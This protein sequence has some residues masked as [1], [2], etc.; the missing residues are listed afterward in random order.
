VVVREEVWIEAGGRVL[1]ADPEH[2][3]PLRRLSLDGNAVEGGQRGARGGSASEL[4]QVSAADGG[5]RY[6]CVHRVPLMS[7][8]D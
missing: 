6:R 4:E 2:A 5:R 3:A 1:A 8:L 7:A